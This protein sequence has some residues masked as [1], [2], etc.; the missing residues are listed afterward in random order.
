MIEKKNLTARQMETA[1]QYYADEHKD[2][3]VDCFV[4]CILTHGGPAKL[5]GCDGKTIQISDIV[6]KFG[7]KNCR[8]L[9]GKPKVFFFQACRG[10]KND[11]IDT[12]TDM[13]TD[14]PESASPDIVDYFLGY[15]SFPGY[16]SYLGSGGSLYI[17]TL[18]DMIK[19]HSGSLDLLEIT[20]KV[21]DEVADKKVQ[22]DGKFYCQTP[23]AQYNLRKRLYFY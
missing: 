14:G 9:E 13:S 17:Q 4:C 15:A 2:I 21:T 1:L 7:N 8:G 10:K 6:S 20:E 5:Y 11:P 22:V 19:K 23:T 12:E 16:V 18:T 3:E